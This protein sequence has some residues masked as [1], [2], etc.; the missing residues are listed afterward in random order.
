MEALPWRPQR[1]R[2]AIDGGIRTDFTDTLEKNAAGQELSAG[3]GG[4]EDSSVEGGTW[5]RVV[6]MGISWFHLGARPKS[7]ELLAWLSWC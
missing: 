1:G 3:A 6:F 7:T 2:G 5:Q 4:R